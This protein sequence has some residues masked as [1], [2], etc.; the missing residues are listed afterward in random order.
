MTIGVGNTIVA[1]DYNSIQNAVQNTL[2]VGSLTLTNVVITNTTGS[3]SCSSSTLVINQF[4][5]VT[6]TNTGTGS[7]TGYT[8]GKIYKISATNAST[9][10]T[11]INLDGTAVATVVGTNGSTT[12]LTFTVSGDRGYGQPVTSTTVNQYDL[13]TAQHMIN[14]KTDIDKISFH[15]VNTASTAPAIGVGGT[16]LANDWTNYSTQITNLTST[17]LTIFGSES[18]PGP[19]VTAQ[20]TWLVDVD[21]QELTNWN[22][23]QRHSVILNFG[24]ADGARYYFNTGSEI[25]FNPRHINNTF[26]KGNSWKTL[27]DNLGT[28]GVRFGANGTTYNT[29]NIGTAIT[30]VFAIGYY[31]L[32]QTNQKIFETIEQSTYSGNDYTIF[33]RLDTVSGRVVFDIFL[34]MILH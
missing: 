23:N 12:G 33:A 18:T 20:S 6:G 1:P 16:I 5:T 30:N 14:L 11:L 7:I 4:V 26:P 25:R 31:Q 17:R 32:T 3:F 21:I 13:V 8:S 29:A 2:G 24:S 9:T 27:F 10:F 22:G 19:I 34:E 15:Q 28:R